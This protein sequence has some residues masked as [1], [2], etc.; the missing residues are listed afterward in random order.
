M[1]V[2]AANNSEHSYRMAA[3]AHKLRL[4]AGKVLPHARFAA[5]PAK[6]GFIGSALIFNF[7]DNHI[8]ENLGNFG[9]VLGE[10]YDR[11]SYAVR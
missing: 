3:A 4:N 5:N 8:V 6:T 10:E 11:I 1:A 9:I 7:R 2:S